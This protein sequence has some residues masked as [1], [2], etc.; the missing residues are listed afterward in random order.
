MSKRSP[1][2]CSRPSARFASLA[3][4]TALVAFALAACT[5]RAL[6]LAGERDGSVADLSVNDAALPP[7][8]AQA[9]DLATCGPVHAHVP[10]P[11]TTLHTLDG[12][13]TW[14]DSTPLR[15]VIS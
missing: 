10:V 6:P 7:D 3:T 2:G 13:S 4:L 8:F 9:S 14:H 1:N 11:L 12:S 5:G 15:V